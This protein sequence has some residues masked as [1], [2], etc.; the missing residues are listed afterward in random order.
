MAVIGAVAKESSDR[1][2]GGFL[3][4][5]SN[6]PEVSAR[7]QSCAWRS[8]RAHWLSALLPLRRNADTATACYVARSDLRKGMTANFYAELSL[9]LC[10]KLK[11]P[12]IQRSA[13]ETVMHLEVSSGRPSSPEADPRNWSLRFRRC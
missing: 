1:F 3:V 5:K 12:S 9:K 7:I 2:P 11:T 13:V 8:A 4:Q 6:G 10:D